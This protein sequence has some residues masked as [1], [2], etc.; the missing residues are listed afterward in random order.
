MIIRCII[1]ITFGQLFWDYL[2]RRRNVETYNKLKTLLVVNED[3]CLG[4]WKNVNSELVT[5]LVN[6]TL[7]AI[8]VKK[9]WLLKLEKT[10]KFNVQNKQ[11]AKN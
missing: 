3:R 5:S 8:T 11:F 9:S 10:M 2:T 7:A 1:S 6:V 4:H